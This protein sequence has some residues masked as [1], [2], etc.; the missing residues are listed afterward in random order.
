MP[1]ICHH[2]HQQKTQSA[3]PY[4]WNGITLASGEAFYEKYFWSNK[5]NEKLRLHLSSRW[6]IVPVC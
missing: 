6:W 3:K 4:F 2:H 1:C 5:K